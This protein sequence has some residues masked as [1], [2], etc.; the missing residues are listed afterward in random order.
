MTR[1]AT[2][3]SGM[4]IIEAESF[5]QMSTLIRSVWFEH[6]LNG[7]K[8]SVHDQWNSDSMEAFEFGAEVG[9]AVKCEGGPLS[10]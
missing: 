8:H 10:N 6:D 9:S 2:E 7:Y 3:Y 4:N 1:V 5:V